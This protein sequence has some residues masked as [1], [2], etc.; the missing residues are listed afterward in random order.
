MIESFK[1]VHTDEA[2]FDIVVEAEHE[3]SCKS[4]ILENVNE[5]ADVFAFAD[6]QLRELAA[7]GVVENIESAKEIKAANGAGAVEAATIND[8]IYAYPMTADNGYFMFY[9]KA[10]LSEEDVKSMDKILAVASN[11]NKKVT[12]D[13]TGWYMYSFFGNTG[14]TLELNPDGIT[15]YCD[16]NSIDKEIK[17]VDVGNAMLAIAKNPGFMSGDDDVLIAG[18]KNDSIIAGVTGVWAAQELQEAWGDNLGATKLPTYTVAGKQVQMSSYAGYKMIGVNAYSKEKEWA[19]ELAQWLTNEENQL[20]R[21]EKRG[22]GPSNIE[23]AS[24]EA[25]A[26][27]PAIQALIAQSEYASLQRVGV[28]YW[29]AAY[30][31]ASAILE[32]KAT[33]DNMQEL[34]NNLVKETTQKVTD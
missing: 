7:A 25:V 9:N 11:L 22:L 15:N 5:A 29:D 12:M 27:S 23:A 3:N 10:Y 33:N 28:K 34:M 13:W 1:A 26:Q 17:G 18:A 4:R 20:L 21:F 16:W 14:L 2:T 30:H 19:A 8:K 32:G 24:N 6:D 31:F